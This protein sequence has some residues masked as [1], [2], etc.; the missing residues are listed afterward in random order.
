MTRRAAILRFALLLRNTWFFTPSCNN[1]KKS[2]LNGIS[3][4]TTAFATPLNKMLFHSLNHG[5][6]RFVLCL[7][8]RIMILKSSHLFSV[9][10][11][12]LPNLFI[13]SLLLVHPTCTFWMLLLSSP[14]SYRPLNADQL[15]G[16]GELISIDCE[17]IALNCEEV[18]PSIFFEIG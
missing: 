9:F 5:K 8:T 17:F 1:R 3:S 14:L 11:S 16:K 7:K 10:H 15:P 2:L 12:S 4:M 13:L 18:T 6:L